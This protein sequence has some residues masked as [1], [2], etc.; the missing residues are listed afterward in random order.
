MV[1]KKTLCRT[2]LTNLPAG[3][4]AEHRKKVL[5]VFLSLFDHYP[6]DIQQGQIMLWLVLG[7]VAGT[8]KK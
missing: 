5:P 1:R 3:N 4:F 6:W 8:T 2:M 7:F